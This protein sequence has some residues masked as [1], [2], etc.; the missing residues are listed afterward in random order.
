M[1]LAAVFDL[2]GLLIDSEPL[3]VRGEIAGFGAAGLPLTEADCALTTGLRL[4]QVVEFWSAHRAW[5]VADPHQVV[6]D[7]QA[8]VAELV[9]AEVTPKPGALEALARLDD[10]GVV[11]S[12]ATSSPP[13]VLDAALD[14]LG[15]RG[16]FR[17]VHSAF[18]ESH[19]KPHPAVYLR[20]VAALDLPARHCV[21]VEDSMHGV[22]A[23]KAGQLLCIAVPEPDRRHDPRFVLADRVLDDLHGLTDELWASLEP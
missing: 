17:S 15:I 7:I 21:A 22:I 18:D 2:D 11:L 16:L 23:A 9:R 4:D 14:R 12:L 20:A 3:W 19:G 8:R 5:S 6:C 13:P 1:S 10:R